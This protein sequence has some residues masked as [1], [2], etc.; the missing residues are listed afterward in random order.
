[1]DSNIVQIFA[2]GIAS[3]LIIYLIGCLFLQQNPVNKLSFVSHLVCFFSGLL[4]LISIYAIFK[5][6]FETIAITLLAAI[7]YFRN[8]FKAL[9]SRGKISSLKFLALS[10][11][12]FI[13][14]AFAQ[15]NFNLQFLSDP[16]SVIDIIHPLTAERMIYSTFVSNFYYFGLEIA[17]LSII[18]QHLSELNTLDGITLY[19]FFEI[20]IA[21]LFKEIINVNSELVLYYFVYPFIKSFFWL[22]V[23][24]ALPKYRHGILLLIFGAVLYFFGFVFYSLPLNYQS[25]KLIIIF[26]L[27]LLILFSVKRNNVNL[28][29][30]A[31]IIA[32]VLNV[33]LLPLSVITFIWLLFYYKLSRKHIITYISFMLFFFLN[34]LIFKFPGG[35]ISMTPLLDK[36][37]M[38]NRMVTMAGIVFREIFRVH[39]LF[40]LIVLFLAFR[41]YENKPLFYRFILYFCLSICLPLLRALLSNVTVESWQLTSIIHIIF[42][43]SVFDVL[44]VLIKE[45]KLYLAG[46][47]IFGVFLLSIFYPTKRFKKEESLHTYEAIYSNDCL[48]EYFSDNLIVGLY[49]NEN[50]SLD[51]H[52][53][54]NKYP[55]YIDKFMRIND[56]KFYLINYDI[57]GLI[58]SVDNL[59]P[60]YMHILVNQL[61]PMYKDKLHSNS[62]L[63]SKDLMLIHKNSKYLGHFENFRKVGMAGPNLIILVNK[64]ILDNAGCD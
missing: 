18:A 28:A 34:F 1:M 16:L 12:S 22:W 20:W 50:D 7:I 33:I 53:I 43:V 38:P 47:L 48:N 2:I 61:K 37:M 39:I 11:A 58:R 40:Y 19:H 4:F 57:D 60:Y 6:E 25:I 27:L 26:Y 5:S 64:N 49:I 9:L 54:A 46:S 3:Y 17:D 21:S 59:D 29:L 30:L 52:H 35:E 32:P 8:T 10:A 36:L 63:S 14:C 51:T 15:V 31:L 24:A 45:N 41:K 55:F 42:I 44:L 56:F 13:L 62:F 23:I